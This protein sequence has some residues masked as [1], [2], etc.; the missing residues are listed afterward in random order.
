METT[1]TLPTHAGDRLRRHPKNRTLKMGQCKSKVGALPGVDDQ[2]SA[3]LK[4]RKSNKRKWRKSK[5]YS[6]SA[7][8]EGDLHCNE[9]EMRKR[10]LNPK[11]GL[12]LVSY[13]VTD[14]E[15]KREC[16]ERRNSL[17]SKA[18]PPSRL[19]RGAASEWVEG[20]TKKLDGREDKQ[21]GS[22][23]PPLA[24]VE[25]GELSC[26]STPARSLPCEPPSPP[27]LRS[28]T[29]ISAEVT[30]VSTSSLSRSG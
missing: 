1:S 22:P 28:V 16:T 17:P 12:V 20:E 7:S 27:A 4:A 13:S 2:D 11:N 24:D 8:L 3:V 15:N 6:L 5:G 14:L 10:G 21:A 29:T 9:E 30:A 18:S 23:S 19:V 26:Y 25:E